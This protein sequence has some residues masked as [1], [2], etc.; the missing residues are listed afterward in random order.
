LKSSTSLNTAAR[1]VRTFDP[2]A[3]EHS[4]VASLEDALDGADAAIVATAHRE[5][6]TL[7]PDVFVKT[8]CAPS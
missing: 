3:P 2:H 1:L 8:A 5:F 4:S 7:T 6:K